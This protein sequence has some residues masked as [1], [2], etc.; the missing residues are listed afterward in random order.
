MQKTETCLFF[1]EMLIFTDAVIERDDEYE[2]IV[3]RSC[4]LSLNVYDELM[5]YDQ[6]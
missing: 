4:S 3:A 2:C 5:E 1:K 6:L